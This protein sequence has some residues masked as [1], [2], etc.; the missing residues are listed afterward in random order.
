[1]KRIVM[2]LL[3]ISLIG[4]TAMAASDK[5]IRNEARFLADKIAY[6]L[7]LDKN[8]LAD[9][10]DINYDFLVRVYPI[11]DKLAENDDNAIREYYRLLAIRN[12]DLRWIMP[13][14]KFLKLLD[15]EYLYR[16]FCTEG[17]K[18]FNRV[19]TKYTNTKK[20]Y[21]G[22]PKTMSKYKGANY[23]EGNSES[24]YRGKYKH[25]VYGGQRSPKSDKFYLSNRLDDFRK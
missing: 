12:G 17:G 22:K 1:M 9:A 19:Y 23:R 16:P 6:E 14:D 2:I 15:V 3:A 18:W 25:V 13:Q 24:A 5:E 10:F 8:Q 11:L 21:E 7:D 4:T 20:F